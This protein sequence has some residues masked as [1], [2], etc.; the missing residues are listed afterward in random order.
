MRNL[1]IVKIGGSVITDIKKQDT[2]DMDSI[3]RLSAEIKKIKEKRPLI[4]GHGSGS[5]AHIPAKRY[6][7]GR[8]LINKGSAFGASLTQDAAARL[9]RILMR[10]LLRKGANPVSFPPSGGA[11]SRNGIISSWDLKP[12]MLA[13]RHGFLPVVHGDVTMDSGQGVA[14][15]STEEALRY[16]ALRLKP[17]LTVMGTDVD[18]VY[19]GYSGAGGGRL[20][21]HIDRHNIG[22]ALGHASDSHKIDVTGGMALKLKALYSI[23][24]KTHSSCMILNA[25][26]PGRLYRAALGMDVPCTAIRF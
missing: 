3:S 6:G 11:V 9:H 20:I 26:V 7:V 25:K 1:V 17:A 2:P 5:F 21:R 24:T 8:G 23:A 22:E 13:L 14:I 19:A 4:L 12:I 15:V 10:E 18:G 16:V